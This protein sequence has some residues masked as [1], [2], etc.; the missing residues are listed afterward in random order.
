[1][2]NA[3]SGAN[4][5]RRGIGENYD[6]VFPPSQTKKVSSNVLACNSSGG[7]LESVS[8]VRQNQW[9]RRSGDRAIDGKASTEQGLFIKAW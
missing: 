8:K 5:V 7:T 1:M 6:D 4:P 2:L 9:V 3:R